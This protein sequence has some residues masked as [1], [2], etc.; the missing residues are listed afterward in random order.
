MTASNGRGKEPLSLE[1]V[2]KRQAQQKEAGSKPKFL[3]KEERAKLALERRAK[4]VEAIHE[5]EAEE[6]QKRIEFFEE[7]KKLAQEEQARRYASSSSRSGGGRDRY[8]DRRSPSPPRS[9]RDDYRSRDYDRNGSDRNDRGDRDRDRD[10][11]RNDRDRDREY[12]DRR[13]DDRRDDRRDRGRLSREG[14]EDGEIDTAGLTP[15][16]MA[17]IRERYMGG[18]WKKRKVRRV[19]DRRFVFDWDAGEDTSVDVN[20]LYNQRVEYTALYRKSGK[21]VVVDNRHWSEKRLSEMKERDWRIFKEDFDIST[22]GGQVPRP[23]RSWRESSIPEPILRVI[24]QV[25]YKDPTP[26]QRQTIPIGLQNRDI[27]GIAETGSGKTASFLIP[28][29]SFIMKLPKITEETAALGPYALIMVPTRELAQQIE[30]EAAKFA[31]PMGF[32]CVSIVGGHSIE[33]QSISLSRGAE[34]VIATPGRLKDCL[35]RHIIVLGQ[36]TYVVM[37]EA[38]RMID[39]GFE[40]DVTFILDKLPVSNAEDGLHGDAGAAQLP[41]AVLKALGG[42]HIRQTTMF[43]AT[44]PTAVERLAQKYLRKPATVV[45]GNAGKAVDT[46]QQIVEFVH[47]ENRK[48]HRLFELLEEYEPPIIVF[49]NQKRSV[50]QYAKMLAKEGYLVAA[51]HGGKSQDTREAAI[52]KLRKGEAQVLLATNVAGRGLDV[53]NVSLVVNFDMSKNIEEYT[54]R[55]GRTGRAG[56]KGTAVTFLTKDD[57]EVLYDLKNLLVKSPVSKCPAE[58]ANHPDAQVKPGTFV[59]KRKYEETLFAK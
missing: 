57:S 35:D 21:Q 8:R 47:D 31:K 15:E 3:S 40:A 49:F 16:E 2:V 38:D 45:I 53:P 42:V 36:C 46:V 54:H 29:L 22:K 26:I 27:I 48:R 1:D 13:R 52:D 12:D 23:I 18:E 30:V 43:S 5:R 25:G 51:L 17:Q 19:N 9:R 39:M 56:K 6:K 24:E 7:A 44:M 50:D 10:R 14:E 59:A 32:R 55:I 11:Y 34:I 37:D 33:E 58:L 28:M 41:E 4:E 20:P